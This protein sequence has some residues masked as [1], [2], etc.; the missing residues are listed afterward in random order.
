MIG[1]YSYYKSAVVRLDGTNLEIAQGTKIGI[2]M[3]GSDISDTSGE[4]FDL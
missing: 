1:S 3:D 2:L 4:S